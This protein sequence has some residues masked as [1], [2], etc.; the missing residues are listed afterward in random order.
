M[1]GS[2]P[3]SPKTAAAMLIEAGFIRRAGRSFK[4]EK[5]IH[6][7]RRRNAE[8]MRKLALDP[9]ARNPTHETAIALA[10][11]Y[12]DDNGL[13]VTDG[14]PQPASLVYGVKDGRIVTRAHV[15]MPGKRMP[16]GL[17]LKSERSRL[18]MKTGTGVISVDHSETM[19][20]LSL[21]EEFPDLSEFDAI[22]IA[23]TGRFVCKHCVNLKQSGLLELRNQLGI[24]RLFIQADVDRF[25]EKNGT[26]GIAF[27][28]DATNKLYFG[29][30]LEISESLHTGLSQ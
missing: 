18:K 9:E 24:A 16:D 5:G 27:Q 10:R 26:P 1:L 6:G 23:T 29:S 25:E 2:A 22:Y 13:A 12:L 14:V 19:A 30:A 4:P 3:E 28:D 11:R 8:G 17:A 7:A 21:S 15:A 20:L